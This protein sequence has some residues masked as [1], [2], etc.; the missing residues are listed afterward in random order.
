MATAT[1]EVWSVGIWATLSLA[2]CTGGDLPGHYWDLIVEGTDN[3]CTGGGAN[4]SDRYEFRALIEGNDLTLAIGDDI[5]ATGIVDGC[6]F[7]YSS[8]VWSAYRDDFEIQWQILGEA[9]VNVGG[10][11]GCVER[12]DW[13]GVETFVVSTSEHPD[14]S[15][16]CT[17]ETQVTGSYLREVQ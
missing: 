5:F 17:Y 8:L 7:T 16:G 13:E 6:T 4:Y 1:R 14:V 10:G 2:A 3:Q 9:R 15:A 11:G 12:T